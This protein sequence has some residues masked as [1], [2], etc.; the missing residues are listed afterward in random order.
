M[1]FNGLDSKQDTIFPP[2]RNDLNRGMKL[3]RRTDNNG[4]WP[5]KSRGLV[6][7]KSQIVRFMSFSGL[8][9]TAAPGQLYYFQASS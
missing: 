2:S 3:E 7:R 9:W 8:C 6:R 1:A 5:L 4:R